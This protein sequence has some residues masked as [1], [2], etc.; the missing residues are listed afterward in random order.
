MLPACRP[1]YGV[2]FLFQSQIACVDESQVATGP[3]Q[4]LKGVENDDVCQYT[5][6]VEVRLPAKGNSKYH[7]ARPVHLIITIIKLNRTSEL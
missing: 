3:D 1:V 2:L 4:G 5:R 6:K 7:G